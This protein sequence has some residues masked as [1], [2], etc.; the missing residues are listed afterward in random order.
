M[1]II[2]AQFSKAMTGVSGTS[3]TGLRVLHHQRPNPPFQPTA[4][5]ARSKVFWQFV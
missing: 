3:L 2:T 4:A 5:H 1:Y